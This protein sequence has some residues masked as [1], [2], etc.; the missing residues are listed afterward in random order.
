MTYNPKTIANY[1]LG[2]AER[3]GT[4]L[5]PM[6]VQ[7]LVYFAHGWFLALRG[8]PL[9]DEQ[10]EA[11]KFGPVIPSLYHAFKEFGNQAIT[12]RATEIE[13]SDALSQTYVDVTVPDLS[14]YTGDPDLD[15]TRR[16]LDRIWTVY[17]QLTAVQLSN[18]THK[19]GTPWFLTWTPMAE[20]PIRGTDVPNTSI[21]DYFREQSTT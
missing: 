12:T 14:S 18:M 7:K 20:N 4:T 9:I 11:W 17:G 21:R 13:V 8:V 2:L 10:V 6:K 19:P 1:F 16:L 15:F 5:S 3:D